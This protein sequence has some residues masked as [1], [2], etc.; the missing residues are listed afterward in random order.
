M[1]FIYEPDRIYLE[2]EEGRLLAEIEMN[3][4]D[5]NTVNICR[6]FVHESLRGH[7]MASKLTEAAVKYLK[8][9]NKNITASCAYAEQWL[10]KH[11][12]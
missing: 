4:V 1:D 12:K 6:T 10:K 9:Q 11:T 3:P 5:E 8:S 2:N 7:G